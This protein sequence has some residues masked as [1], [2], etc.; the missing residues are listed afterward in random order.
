[1]LEVRK[2]T[3]ARSYENVFFREFANSLAQKFV[4]KNLDG[5][6][7]GSPFC[8]VEERLQIDALLIT[9]HAI[10]IID[11]KNYSERINLPEIRDFKQ[12]IWTIDNGTIIKGGSSVNPYVQLSVQNNRF[13]KVLKL[14]IVNSIKSSD[15][16]NIRHADKIVCFQHDIT[17]NG[18][19]PEKYSNFHI[20][21]KSHYLEKIFDVIDIKNE[22]SLSVDSFEAF[23]RYFQADLYE[24]NIVQSE[25]IVEETIQMFEET[26]VL[27][28]EQFKAL[29]ALEKFIKDPDKQVFVL[30]GSLRSG[31]SSLIPHIQ[32]LAFKNGMLQA[33]VFV[34]SARI[35]NNLM[36]DVGSDEVHSIYSYIYGGKRTVQNENEEDTDDQTVAQLE[37]IPLKECDAE[38]GSIFIVDEAHLITDSLH[39]TLDLMFGSGHLLSDFIRFSGT[40]KMIFIGDPYLLHIGNASTNALNSSYLEEKY[41][42]KADT[43]QL[44]DNLSSSSIVAESL[45]C[46]QAIRTNKFNFFDITFRDNVINLPK[47]GILETFKKSLFDEKISRI[48]TYTNEDA[49]AVNL[50]I[51]NQLLSNGGDIAAGDLISFYNNFLCSGSDP[52]STVQKIYNGEFATVLS[53]SPEPILEP[54]PIKGRTDVVVL[55]FREIVLKISNSGKIITVLS[56]ENFRL[57]QKSELPNEETLAFKI[58][59]NQLISKEA[60]A[61]SFEQST[62]YNHMQKS[63]EYVALK[64]EIAKLQTELDNGEKVKSKLDEKQRELRKLERN[65]KRKY[66]D[67]LEQALLKNPDS[68]YF[69]YKNSACMRFGWAMTVHRSMAYKFDNVFF[70]VDQGKDKGRNNV[71]YLKWLY[72]GMSRA[73]DKLYLINYKQ[74]NPFQNIQI[75]DN[76]TQIDQGPAKSAWFHSKKE[77]AGRLED[78]YAFMKNECELKLCVIVNVEPLL[79]QERYFIQGNNQE[80]CVLSILYNKEG[81]FH[82]PKVLKS[83]PPEFGKNLVDHLQ[84]ASR[85]NDEFLFNL[86]FVNESW[87][88]ES[89]RLLNKLLS[90]MKISISN[91]KES[92]Y[93]DIV[94]LNC[95]ENTLEVDIWYDDSGMYSKISSRHYSDAAIWESFKQVIEIAKQGAKY[96]EQ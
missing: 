9:K 31:K 71:S 47:E 1:M 51:K 57:N 83:V 36:K 61:F 87:R 63:D 10:C 41:G 37:V 17:I 74:I 42:I 29:K 23:K 75:S 92:S 72:S 15:I 93:H 8:E 64:R 95:Y 81:K 48:L 49:N 68:T 39:K 56:F 59:L 38:E 88:R 53:V 54:I 69:K 90:P 5:L 14:Y 79:W 73:V 3:F 44:P 33:E 96:G 67:R 89:Y 91:I 19:I 12:G 28:D 35:A 34:S 26:S 55:K 70:N 85:S 32:E 25:V 66:R 94:T 4:D 13:E 45:K 58:L 18:E 52:F 50:W 86:E 46:V 84:S 82:I 30:S 22:T 76:N 60:N 21:D 2:N 78:L 16:L 27:H 24:V 6:L 43:F 77:Q 7:I 20:T 40:R 65:E 62:E 11:F 80:T